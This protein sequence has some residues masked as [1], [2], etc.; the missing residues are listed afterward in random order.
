MHVRQMR[1][2]L[3]ALC[4]GL[5]LVGAI[6]IGWAVCGQGP[7]APEPSRP[8]ATR[9]AKPPATASAAVPTLDEFARVWQKPLRRP[10][11]DPPPTAPPIATSEPKR[12][13]LNIKL[14]GT[15]IEPGESLAMIATPPNTLEVRGLG[16]T[17]GEGANQLE[18][19]EIMPDRVVL[20]RQ[21]ERLVLEIEPR[22]GN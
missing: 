1:F 17:I 12:A 16:D 14:L 9:E 4:G 2:G 7:E 22:K 11:F 18:V 10:I 19:V 20:R 5:W 13:P 3:K 15:A 8:A 21:S 6:V